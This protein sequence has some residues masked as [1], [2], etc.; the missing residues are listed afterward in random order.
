MYERGN[1]RTPRGNQESIDISDS[2][3]MALSS[4]TWTE[5]GLEGV[6]EHDDQA[7]AL[8]LVSIAAKKISTGFSFRFL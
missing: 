8:W 6:G 1:V 5:K 7:M 3:G 2:L 4:V